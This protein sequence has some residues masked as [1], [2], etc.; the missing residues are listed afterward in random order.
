VKMTAVISLVKTDAGA[1]G[2]VEAIRLLPGIDVRRKHIVLKPDLNTAD[3]YPGSTGTYTLRSLIRTLKINGAGKIT[4]AERSGP[5]STRRVFEVKQIYKLSE[6]LGFD[7][8]NLDEIQADGWIKIE[9]S[10]RWANGFNFA[11]VYSKAECIIQTCCLKTDRSG[12]FCM[13]LAN[14]IRMADRQSA[15][16][17]Q[18]SPDREK[19]IADINSAYTPD[20]VI[21]DGTTAFTSGGPSLGC[22]VPAGVIVASR[23]R[24]AVDATGIAILRLLGTT[25]ELSRGSIFD[26]PQIAAAV[27][28]GLGVTNPDDIEFV[29]GDSPSRKFAEKIKTVL[30]KQHLVFASA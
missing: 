18:A 11:A 8:V 24:V 21:M 15:L 4:L 10:V 13:S 9:S 19:M 6:E 22:C 29:T 30:Q 5:A 3:P 12:G 16:D 25:P 7:I 2:L 26:S 17:L 1:A 14:S 23:D 28:A 20:L 27:S